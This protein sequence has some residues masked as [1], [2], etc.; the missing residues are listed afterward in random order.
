[1][2]TLTLFTSAFATKPEFITIQVDET[3]VSGECNGFA[4]I[5]H[6]EG[7]VKASFRLAQNGNPAMEILR[8]RLRHTFSNSE[9]GESLTSPDVGIDKV[10][11]NEDGPL[12]VAV[13]GIVTRVV[14]PGEGPVFVHLGR[15]VFDAATGEVVFEAGRHDDFA[16]LLPALCSALG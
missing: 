1:M 7:T 11:F 13:I 9:T 5:E 14:V 3:F 12:T 2:L 15:I 10:T 8:F 4:V 6:V 16:D